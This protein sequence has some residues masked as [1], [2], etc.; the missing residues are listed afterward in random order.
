MRRARVMAKKKDVKVS[1]GVGLDVGTMNLVSARSTSQGEKT[2]RVRDAFLNLDPHKH[3]RML[4]MSNTPF[5]ERDG[6]EELIVVGDAVLEFAS[7]L[8]REPRRPLSDGLISSSEVDSLEILGV[9]I[10]SVLGDPVEEDEV[11]YF[12]VPSAPVDADRDVIYHTRAFERIISECG[13][14][15]Y[16]S[17][18]AIAIIYSDAVDDGFSGIGISFG[19]GMVNVGLAVKALSGMTFSIAR[20]GDWID[21]GVAN[22]IGES[23]AQ[24][25][26]VKERGINLLNPKEGD[27]RHYR[28]REALEFYYRELIDSALKEVATQ[29]RENCKLD[30]K[31]PIPLIVSG[32]TSLA[33][34]FMDLFQQVFKKHRRRFP[35]ELSEIRHAVDPLNAVAY[36]L[37]TQALQEYDV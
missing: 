27:D 34:G 4:Q 30:L 24:V 11:C 15:A 37:L 13:Y 5:F 10:K 36:G 25:C 16:P 35:I 14:L 1:P 8:D 22:S 26:S 18:E 20:G 9:L 2:S 17:N 32:G 28:I 23:Q 31:E 7:M 21:R 33:G 29:F 19:S 3:K 6:G 12:S